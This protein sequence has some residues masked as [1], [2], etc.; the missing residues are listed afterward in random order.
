[1]LIFRLSEFT[2]KIQNK[3]YCKEQSDDKDVH[4][5]KFHKRRLGN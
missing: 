4:F 1:M 2:T 3:D 5:Y